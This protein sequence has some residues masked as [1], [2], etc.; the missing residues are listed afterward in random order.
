MRRLACVLALL[1]G[2]KGAGS[3]SGSSSASTST[4]SSTSP[5]PDACSLLTQSE[6]EAVLG[7][8][9][10]APHPDSTKNGCAYETAGNE[11]FVIVPEWT[12]GKFQLDTERMIGGLVSS[13]AGGTGVEA[14]TLEGPWDEAA[15]GPRDLVFRVKARALTVTYANSG[16]DIPGAIKLA[17]HA[18]VRMAAVP[19]PERPKESS[20]KC[21]LT[22]EV[23]GEIIGQEVRVAPGQGLRQDACD[24]DLVLDPT[25]QVELKVQ[26]DAI[27]EMVFESMT[28]GAK[29]ALG[30]AAELNKIDVGEGGLAFERKG[31]GGEAAARANGKVYHA[32]MAVGITSSASIPEGAMVKLVERMIH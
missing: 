23:V 26:P 16:T 14:D 20:D 13:V 21:P 1:A 2:C 12:Y 3:E 9:A 19:E 32:R 18:L 7:P 17:S 29:G 10:Q 4:T 11:W 6:A 28:A 24:F 30:P 22:A 15:I 5:W 25:V 31:G 27:A 8:L